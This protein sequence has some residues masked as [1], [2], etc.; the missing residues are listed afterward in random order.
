MIR[1]DY[2]GPIGRIASTFV[3][4]EDHGWLGEQ[5]W[6]WWA[7]HVG[8]EPYATTAECLAH[9]QQ[10]GARPVSWIE[11]VRKGKYPE[12]THVEHG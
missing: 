9:L 11:I 7:K 3:H 8:G 10:H 12:V 4:V 1:V 2:A 6:R 5:A